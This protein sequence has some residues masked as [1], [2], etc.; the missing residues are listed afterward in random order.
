MNV[1]WICE[2]GKT[3][4]DRDGNERAVISKCWAH[5]AMENTPEFLLTVKA[6][7]EPPEVKRRKFREKRGAKRA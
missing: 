4:Y 2:C 1:T 5:L 6:T 7:Q 3:L